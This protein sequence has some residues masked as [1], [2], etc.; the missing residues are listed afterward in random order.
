MK[1]NDVGRAC[2]MHGTGEKNLQGF[3]GK[4]QRKETTQETEA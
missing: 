4:T 1:Q 3:D 2:G